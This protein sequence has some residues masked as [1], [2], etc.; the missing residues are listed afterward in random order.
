M[1][2]TSRAFVF[3][4]ALAAAGALRAQSGAGL[5]LI[6]GNGQVVSEQFLTAQPLVVQA[7]DASGK[8]VAG[9]AV[10]WTLTPQLSGTIVRPSATT[11]SNGMASANFL[12]TALQSGLSF[13]SST[14]TAS[15]TAGTVNFVVTTVLVRIPNG[16][17]PRPLVQ[18]LTPILGAT[19]TGPAGSVLPGAVVVQVTAQ[20]GPQS[21]QPVPNV[22]VQLADALDPT[23]KPL[24]ACNGPG[25]M[26]LTDATGIATCDMVLGPQP[27]SEQLLAAVGGFQNT[28]AFSLVVTAAVQCSFAVTP[29]TQAFGAAGGNGTAT[30]TAG[31]SCG[32]TASSN[33]SWITITSSAAGNGNGSIGYSVAANTGPARSGTISVAQKTLTV[34]QSAVGGP[35][36][37]SI[38]TTTLPVGTAGKAYTASLSATGGVA[39]YS[40][41]ETGALPPGL[42]LTQSNGAISGTP[43]T[44]GSYSFT[45]RVSDSAGSAATQALTLLVTGS[46]GSGGVTITN[47]SFP[48]ATLNQPYQQALTSS[49]G[50]VTPFSPAPSF[51]LVGGNLP[52]GISVAQVP[53]VGWAVAGTPTSAGTFNFTLAALDAC[54][55]SGQASF[56]IDVLTSGPPPAGLT[57]TPTSLLFTVQSGGSTR[58]PDQPVAIATTGGPV[59]FTATAATA[60][61]GNWLTITSA[62]SGTAPAT[63]T[64]GVTNFGTLAPGVYTGAIGITPTGGTPVPVNV[65]LTVTAGASL[66]VSPTALSFSFQSGA[67]VATAQEPISVVSSTPTSYTISS[68]GAPWLSVNPTSGTTPQTVQVSVNAA[69]MT[70]GSYNA[71]LTVAPTS[72]SPVTVLVSLSIAAPITITSSPTALAFT[73]V[74]G[75]SAP[76]PQNLQLSTSNGTVGFNLATN[77]SGGNWLAV[78]ASAS[79]L[80]CSLSVSIVNLSSL[81]P[82]TYNGSISIV[83]FDATITPIT[84]TVSL[85]VSAAPPVVTAVTNAATFQPGAVAPGE[86]VVLFGSN[87]GPSTLA[88]GTVTQNVLG[89]TA[90]GTRVLFDNVAAPVIYSSQGQVA[91]IVPYGV[92]GNTATAIQVEFNGVRSAQL[93]MSV[94]DVSPGL[95]PVIQNQDTSVNAPQNGAAPGSIVVLYATGGGVMTPAVPDGSLVLALP[96]QMPVGAVSVQIGGQPAQVIYAGAAPGEVSGLMQINVVVPPA[97]PSGQ[98]VPVVL[99]VGQTSSPAFNL[100][101]Q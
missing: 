36:P 48:A 47:T 86:I 61:G 55:N 90:A 27:G 58:P 22:G 10:N 83:P 88:S 65:T 79:T 28:R 57:A 1:I 2:R 74:P 50:C 39:P 69:G 29:A 92:A 95:F 62:A 73:V 78:S 51:S 82:G 71:T 6:S 101:T 14:V 77:S 9:L 63:L 53:N 30:I 15:S 43:T 3:C 76:N 17:A 11:D 75:G 72:G 38:T 13:Q 44:A 100:S 67:G 85:T 80:P 81:A 91:A 97:T 8:P 23:M 60:S 20:A 99:T 93:T 21:G 40:W 35:N 94:T 45:A 56:H 25:G 87:L 64:I 98:S 12:A 68:S 16:P 89:T 70:P 59:G 34:T 66:V 96:Y 84:V 37:L 49:G 42:S 46:T 19:L 52:P 4:L 5:F 54:G 24:A 33:A 18:L 31:A 32:W 26:V 7:R 41:T